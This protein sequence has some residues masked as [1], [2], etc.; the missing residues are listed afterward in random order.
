MRSHEDRR[1]VVARRARGHQLV[2]V[3]EVHGDEP[4]APHR[5]ELVERRALDVALRGGDDHRVA[6]EVRD[7]HHRRHVVAVLDLDEVD[8]RDA[9]RLALALWHL[10]A[11]ER[12]DASALGEEQQRVV[13]VADHEVVDGVFLARGSAGHAA[14]A[15]ALQ[16]VRLQRDALHVAAVGDGDDDLLV[17][18]EV[19]V[20]DLVDGWSE[21]LRTAVVAVVRHELA[22]VVLD[23]RVDLPGVREQVLE[24][25]DLLH[26]LGV[27]VH[28]ALL[29]KRGEAA[30]LHVE[31]RLRLP[32]GQVERL[33]AGSVGCE[34]GHGR[35]V[36]FAAHQH[37]L[38]RVGGLRVADHGDDLVEAV[39]GLE[40]AIEHVGAVLRLLEVELAAPGDD[41][42]AVLDER[43]QGFPEAHRLRPPA[44]EGEHV[45]GEGRL[46]RGQPEQLVLNRGGGARP[47]QLDHHAHAV[48]VG[49]VA[50]V[51]DALDA[52]SADQV[53]DALDEGGLVH[54]VGQL[55]DDDLEPAA[56]GLL[57]VEDAAHGDLPASGGVGLTD[58][59]LAEDAAARREVRP[60]DVLHEVLDACLRVVDEVDERVA[61]LVEVVRRH[62]GRHADGDAG[63]AVEQEVRQPRR[64][65]HR[66]VHGVVEVG[67]E[68]DRVA[69]EVGEHLGGD[70]REA[71]LGVSHLRG[72]VTVDGAEV[73]LAGDERV[74]ERERLREAH[75]GVVD[76]GV[77]VGME[78]AHHLA[79][80][81]RRLLERRGRPDAELL[82]PEQHP[83]LHGFEAVAHV[84][85][86][87][88]DDDRH[89]VVEVRVPHLVF[90]TGGL[91][92][93]GSVL[94]QW[95]ASGVG[96]RARCS[97]E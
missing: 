37:R 35:P 71:G 26:E 11:L 9:A 44:H 64:Q 84:R 4:G 67:L 96:E 56:R 51:G 90:D 12:V 15:P 5:L 41:L 66:L 83:A 17:R 14:P 61:D 55:V 68:V 40:Q 63:G 92:A 50:E 43:L 53:C 22:A 65:H 20:G 47:A 60:A 19:L 34:G 70:G 86:R 18:D 73:A 8:H 62:A 32:I 95:A 27:L 76:G 75:E 93:V 38:R 42:A 21:D 85:Q 6:A 49:L 46:Q 78:L 1:V 94:N 24:V 45:H 7:H 59:L 79:D 13:R 72:R 3:L 52:A 54:L 25:R 16:P 88:R 57:G 10:V 89:R 28:D 39:D 36:E 91:D 81:A 31:N 48:A 58:G 77:A 80:D 30:Q 97:G 23:Q 29:L 82:H 74:A 33:D 69:V 87:A 2:A